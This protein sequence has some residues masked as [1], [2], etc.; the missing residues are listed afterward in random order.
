MIIIPE[1]P[2]E[3]TVYAKIPLEILIP[4]FPRMTSGQ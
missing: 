2:G 1:I 4:G 3:I